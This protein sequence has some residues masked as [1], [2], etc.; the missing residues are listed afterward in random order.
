MKLADYVK[1]M[2]IDLREADGIPSTSDLKIVQ[3][4]G[5]TLE[6]MDEDAAIMDVDLKLSEACVFNF[7]KHMDAIVC[8][9]DAAREEHKKYTKLNVAQQNSKEYDRRYKEKPGN[10]I[11]YKR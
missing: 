10:R 9:E 3:N 1:I 7:A 6:S 4:R 11:R 2:G 5:S 8:Q